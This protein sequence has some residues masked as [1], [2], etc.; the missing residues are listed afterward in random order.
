MNKDTFIIRVE[1]YDAISELDNDEQA[2]LFR[3]LFAYHIGT[4]I[5]L[6]NEPL[7]LRL[8]WKLIEPSLNRAIESYDK[9]RETSRANGALGG[10]PE[11]GT[12]NLDK[13]NNNLNNQT[14]NISKTYKPIETLSDSVSVPVSDSDSEGVSKNDIP[15]CLKKNAIDILP[16]PGE[17]SQVQYYEM[18]GMRYSF[19]MPDLKI[20]HAAWC[21]DRTS[22]DF[23]TLKKARQNFEGYCA[24]WKMNAAAAKNKA[25]PTAS[26]RKVTVYTEQD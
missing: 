7:S 14:V 4:E 25:S 2:S 11:K 26:I 3:Y 12:K 15:V 18:I 5:D 21:G 9:R 23:E 22:D 17:A 24:R 13:P 10:R 8:V 20:L 16:A 1:W 19:T 6:S